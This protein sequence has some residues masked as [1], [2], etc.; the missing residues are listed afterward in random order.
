MAKYEKKKTLAQKQEEGTTPPP[1]ML[2]CQTI[3][4]PRYNSL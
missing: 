1:K 3:N 4:S 2:V